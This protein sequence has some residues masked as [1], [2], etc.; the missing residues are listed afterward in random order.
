MRWARVAGF[1]LF[2]LVLHLVL[3]EAYSRPVLRWHK[4]VRSDRAFLS[5]P[6]DI[7]L[8]VVGD[9][10]ARTAVLGPLV[11]PRVANISFGGHDQLKT[12]YRTK[13]LVERGEKRVSAILV[14]LDPVSFSPWRVDVFSPE[15][16][17][18]RYV[19]FLEVGR[20]DGHP[21]RYLGRWLKAR[22][23]PYAGELR[24]LNQLRRGRFGFGEDLPNGDFS[25]NGP[26]RRRELA[27]R[28][29]VDHFGF[30]DHAHPLLRWGFASLVAWAEERQMQVVAIAYPVTGEYR[31]E[32]DATDAPEQVRAQVLE[33][34]L[35]DPRHVFLN[36]LRTFEDRPELFSDPH[37]LNHR[38]RAEF[39]RLLRAELTA[40][41]ILPDRGG[42]S[43]FPSPDEEQ[44]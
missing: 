32:A 10:H 35:A 33:P 6:K 12:W 7:D 42:A 19:D 14:P 3:V 15:L 37:H 1:L 41:G 40:R 31:A 36:H 16:V 18:G 4:A 11:G 13:A 24:T 25:E 26:L 9:S 2:G 43:D 34:F 23:F 38:G 22:V 21:A 39:S 29:A 20:V 27:R 8:L 44:E 28:D 17:W 5:A 30:E